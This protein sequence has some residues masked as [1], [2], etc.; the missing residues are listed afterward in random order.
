MRCYLVQH[1]AAVSEEVDPA[2]PLSERGK[3][4]V[5]KVADVVLPHIDVRKIFHSGK[6]RA[7]QTAEIFVEQ[8]NVPLEVSDGLAP[9]DAAEIWAQRLNDID[10]PVMVVG[11]LPHLARLCGLLL[12]NDIEAVPVRFSMGGVVCLEREDGRWSV[13]WMVIPQ[14]L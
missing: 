4:E 8:L 2:R 12:C 9:L 6:L 7:R 13:S 1:G 14:I 3:I 10:T 11:H 5:R